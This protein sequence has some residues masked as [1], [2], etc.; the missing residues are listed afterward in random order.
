MTRRE[1]QRKLEEINNIFNSLSIEPEFTKI[2]K[3]TEN[4]SD[5]P[6][7]QSW[8]GIEQSIEMINVIYGN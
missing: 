8:K 7:T 3:D 5:I 4:F 1:I 6:L 2:A